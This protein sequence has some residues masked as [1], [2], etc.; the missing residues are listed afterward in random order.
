[1][2]VVPLGMAWLLA[3]FYHRASSPTG[4]GVRRAGAQHVII[5]LLIVP[6]AVYGLTFLPLLA[7]PGPDSTLAGLWQHQLAIWHEHT[8]AL[9]A[10]VQSSRWYQWPFNFRPMAFWFE[11]DGMQH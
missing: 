4:S 9:P 7:L 3:A 10:A 1:F 6:A 8:T 5:A 2:G 11:R